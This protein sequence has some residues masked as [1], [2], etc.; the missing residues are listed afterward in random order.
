VQVRE[1][2]MADRELYE[3]ARDAVAAAV[4]GG[5]RLILN[6]RVDVAAL[7]NAAGVHV[8]GDDLPAAAARS[9]LGEDAVIGF[10][11]HG[12]QDAIA[13]ASS[14]PLDYVALGPIFPTEHAS[15]SRPA[16]G[17][18][19]V[20]RA[21]SAIRIPLVAIGG[22]NRERAREVL[23]A[24]AASVAVLGDIMSSPDIP[25]AAAAYLA[26]GG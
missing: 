4:A 15:V 8:G 7:V 18:L 11:A 1:K 22:M 24:G 26:L 12:A 2:A 5:A 20:E 21:A 9:I 19:A 16:L 23:Q 10:S 17:V 14:M 6:D 13:A 25:A 3:A